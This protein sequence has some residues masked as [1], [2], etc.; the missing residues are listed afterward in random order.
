MVGELG[1]KCF[2]IVMLVN[3]LS[4]ETLICG[5]S[6]RLSSFPLSLSPLAL[7]LSVLYPSWRTE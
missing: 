7:G 1:V 5:W 4:A 6:L 2:Q 3:M